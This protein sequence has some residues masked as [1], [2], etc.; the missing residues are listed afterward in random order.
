[1]LSALDLDAAD[2]AALVE[3]VAA[4]TRVQ[5][6]AHALAAR[7]AATLSER[8]S[9]RPT[10]SEMAGGAPTQ[11]CVAGDELAMRL[12]WS[13]R[14]ATRLVEHGRV[15]GHVLGATG[16]A[17]ESGEIGVVAAQVVADR[18]AG[19]PV[20]IALTVQDHVLP[21]AG[22]RTPT[23]LRRDLERALI[24]VDPAEAASR[25][26]HAR[27]GR[28]V[29]RPRVLPDGMAGLWAVLPAATAARI[30]A[31]LDTAARTARS[32]G[33]ERTL[34][35]LRADGLSDLVLH[36]ACAVSAQPSALPPLGAGHAGGFPD[37]VHVPG[38]RCPPAGT[39]HPDGPHPCPVARHGRARV[40]VTVALS[41][42]LGIDDEP[43]D[44]AGYGPVDAT[45]ARALAEGGI[46]RRVVTDPL[47]GTVLDVGR[48]RYRPPAGMVEH[49]QA[50]DRTC[51]RPGCSATA[52]SCDL[53]HTVEFHAA[54]ERPPPA[55]AGAAPPGIARPDT[56]RPD[57]ARPDTA[58]SDTVLSDTV[59]SDTARSDTAPSHTARPS[60]LGRTAADN[61]GPLCRRDHRLKTDGGF[62]LRQTAPGVYEWI[63]PTGHRYRVVPGDDGR[64]MH[65]GAGWPNLEPPPF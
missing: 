1:M 27:T 21:E 53:D 12:C 17:L 23:Q 50:R 45:T 9:M 61:L 33:D 26:V 39:E 22:R 7:A 40:R 42:L 19:L 13:R 28:R 54:T 57:T 44:L 31:T 35:Q 49:V 29:D 2:D 55:P 51:A 16:E 43:A 52:E 63:T 64:H 36:T 58:L 30:D 24:A 65:L 4:A 5:G 15:F 48:T 25:Q 60:G 41:T 3:V 62:I 34:D 32:A 47:S 11:A 59:P 38:D 14:A 37:A 18:L 46:W 8:D 10:W 20:E 6:W 56:A